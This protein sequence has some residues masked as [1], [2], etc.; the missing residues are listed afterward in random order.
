[1]DVPGY[2]DQHR[3]DQI[4]I[5]DEASVRNKSQDFK[6]LSLSDGVEWSKLR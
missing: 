1:M 5:K 3:D 6:Y 4:A 2:L